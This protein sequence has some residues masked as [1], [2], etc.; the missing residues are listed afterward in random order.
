MQGRN[1][2]QTAVE[3]RTGKFQTS[4]VILLVGITTCVY[5]AQD[6]RATSQEQSLGEIA[7]K[8]SARKAKTVITDDDLPRRTLESSQSTDAPRP[9]AVSGER[10]SSEERGVNNATDPALKVPGSLVE[11]R[12]IIETLK[13]HEQQLTHRYDE[14]QRKLRNT[15][16]EQLR[17]VYSD[18]LAGREE[19]LALIHK[20]IA[21][22]EKAVR[23]A[24]EAGKAQGGQ[25][26]APK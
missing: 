11:A 22:A 19:N 3:R 8:K 17:R 9:Q 2:Q 18:A 16:N 10:M 5:G 15:E 1:L 20:Q 12:S 4:W 23:L 13:L 26:D 21:E 6:Q 7:H 14:I 24:E 25:T